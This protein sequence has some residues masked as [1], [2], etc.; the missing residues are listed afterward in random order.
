[1]KPSG[2]GRH[3]VQRTHLEKIKIEAR[4]QKILPHCLELKK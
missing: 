1:M 4:K 2:P 3:K